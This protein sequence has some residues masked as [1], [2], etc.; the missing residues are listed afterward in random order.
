MTGINPATPSQ[1]TNTGAPPAPPAN[2]PEQR[3]SQQRAETARPVTA[4]DSSERSN[5][6]DRDRTGG[7]AEDSAPSRETRAPESSQQSGT[8]REARDSEARSEASDRQVT[9]QR[10]EQRNEVSQRGRTVDLFA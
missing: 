6:Q 9:E 4:P 7:R 1:P 5:V 10:A 8:A 2:A 3:D